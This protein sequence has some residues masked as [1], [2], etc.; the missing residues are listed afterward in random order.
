[1]VVCLYAQLNCCEAPEVV[2]AVKL[3]EVT[4]DCNR[5]S[6]TPDLEAG[7][8]RSLMLGAVYRVADFLASGNIEPEDAVLTHY[9]QAPFRVFLMHHQ[10]VDKPVHLWW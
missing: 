7:V 4:R 6:G 9:R 3:R 1:M 10:F 5:V 8:E 2:R